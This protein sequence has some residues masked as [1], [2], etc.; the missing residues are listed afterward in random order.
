MGLA[1]YI[2]RRILFSFFVILGELAIVFYLTNIAAPNPAVIWA[3]PESTQQQVQLVTELYHLNSPWYIQFLYY[4]RNIFTGNWGTSPLYQRP[5]LSLIEQYL[6]VT[7]ELAIISFVIKV[8]AETLLGVVSAVRA[9]GLVD[10]AIKWFYT[11]TRSLPPFLLALGL[12]LIFS[13]D[14]KVL[15]SS[16][17]IN[18]L[19]A[20]NTPAFKVY[21]PFT[22]RYVGFWLI[23]NMPVLNALL[24]GDWA[25]AKSGLVHAILPACTLI[26]FGFGGLVRL[27]KVSMLDALQSDYVRTARS[28]GLSERAV[29]F[30]HALR[31]SL[32]PATTLMGLLFAQL[33]AGSLVVETVF[34]YYGLGY[35]LGQS[36][37]TFDTPSLIAGT[38]LITTIIVLSNL[39]TDI[40]YGVLDPRTR[41]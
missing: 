6:P 29:V 8:L 34:D 31:N 2:S 37:L 35:Y 30:G 28:K 36:L 4:L 18:P 5:V 24:V 3:G 20:L 22:G 15:P 23:D 33:V 10:N 11:V 16:Q 1:A 40:A 9:G 41:V 32:L 25:A 39:A 14:L 26:L 17:P 7:L 27:I 19:L 38:V 21:D 12:L 13:Y